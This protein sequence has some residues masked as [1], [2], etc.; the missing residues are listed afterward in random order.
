MCGQVITL[1]SEVINNY[2]NLHMFNQYFF[3]LEYGIIME[4]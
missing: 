4:K 3:K 1:P 2:E